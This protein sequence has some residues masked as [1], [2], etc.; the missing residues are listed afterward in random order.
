MR[1]GTSSA[2]FI[3]QP[4]A[5]Q[6]SVNERQR[7]PLHALHPQQGVTLL[8]HEIERQ[9]NCTALAANAVRAKRIVQMRQHPCPLPLNGKVKYAPLPPSGLTTKRLAATGN[10]YNQH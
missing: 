5:A 6:H 2:I 7:H 10:K 8:L 4:S 9:L 3:V 1:K